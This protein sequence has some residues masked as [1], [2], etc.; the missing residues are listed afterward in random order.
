M[1]ITD[2]FEQYLG[3]IDQGWRDNNSED[4][5]Q[6]V[7][8]QNTPFD[9]AV[10][11]LTLGLS[12][13]KLKM[14]NSREVKQ[15]LVFSVYKGVATELIVNCLLFLCELII[16]DHGAFLRGR[17]VTLPS[18]LALKLGFDSLYC[19]IPV[20]WEDEFS[21]YHKSMPATVLVQIIPI[22]KSEAVYI[23]G[24][25]WDKFEDILEE[26]D[27]DLFSLVRKSVI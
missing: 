24:N 14:P 5:F 3:T 13:H 12:N 25:G 19:T 6:V 10:T 27:P 16:K 9:S 23:S 26:K 21:T 11:F 7:S 1:A 22:H 15:E 8:F 17:V 2:H 18:E 4:G 20:F